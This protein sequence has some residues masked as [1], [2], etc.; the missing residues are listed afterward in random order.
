MGILVVLMFYAV[1]LT[2][3]AI[4][5]SAVLAAMAKSYLRDIPKKKKPIFY[6]AAFPF[7][8]VLFAGIW[9]V[10][11][12]VMNVMI[13]HHDPMLGDGWFTD[14]G[15]GYAIEMIDVTD[16]GIVY[17][18][19][20][21]DN[22]INGPNAIQGVRRLQISGSQMF[23]TSDTKVFQNFGSGIQGEDD[24]F[25][26][27]TRNREV[28]HFSDATALAVAAQQLGV[29]LKLE[30][31]ASVYQKFRWGWFDALAAFILFALP[32]C[33]LWRLL[34]YIGTVKRDYLTV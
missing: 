32:M 9:F 17:P 21:G 33:G 3:L 26:L 10:S 20:G 6:A 7:A 25:S 24:F 5:T 8:C 22:D 31:I 15:N 28:K 12:A 4:G 19:L 27:N 2:I 29:Q 13:F 1:V 30:P 18:R 14:I 23:G 34:Q 16:H 11:Y